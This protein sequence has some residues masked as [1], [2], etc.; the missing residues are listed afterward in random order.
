MKTFIADIIPKIRRFSQELDNI[1]LLTNQHWVVIDEINNSKTVYIFRS[2]GELLI[3]QNGIVEKARWEYL[4]SNSLLIDKKDISYLFRH[5]FFDENV[6]ALKVD[7]KEEYAFLINE[8]KFTGEMNSIHSITGFLSAKYINNPVP[9]V[10]L[11]EKNKQLSYDITFIKG[12]SS[13]ENGLYDEYSVVLSNG[14]TFKVFQKGLDESFFIKR[15]EGF[16]Y[17]QSKDECIDY[18]VQL[19]AI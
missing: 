16:V 12:H 17:F 5:G 4:G 13:L 9:K 2:S 3:S 7:G 14:S 8:T 18:L 15:G 19:D 6:L 11:S 1:T 10:K